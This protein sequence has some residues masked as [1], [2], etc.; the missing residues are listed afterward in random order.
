MKKNKL[1]QEA[2]NLENKL[3]ELGKVSKS[4]PTQIISSDSYQ[5]H[6]PHKETSNKVMSE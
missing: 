4:R 3:K 6:T 1:S 5:F 2:K